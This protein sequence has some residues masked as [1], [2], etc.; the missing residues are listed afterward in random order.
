MDSSAGPYPILHPMHEFPFELLIYPYIIFGTVG[1][2]SHSV[3]IPVESYEI[4][5]NT[6]LDMTNFEENCILVLKDIV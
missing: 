3:Y 5:V 6:K 4:P 1:H 2:F